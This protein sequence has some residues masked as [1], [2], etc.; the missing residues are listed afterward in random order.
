MRTLLIEQVFSSEALISGV[1]RK[2]AALNAAMKADLQPILTVTGGRLA[3]SQTDTRLQ[4]KARMH[5]TR[6]T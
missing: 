5:T 6:P 4:C 1:L 3:L 2:L